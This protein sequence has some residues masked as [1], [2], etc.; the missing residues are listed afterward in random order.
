ML[1]HPWRSEIYVFGKKLINVFK[2][3]EMELNITKL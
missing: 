1:E 2:N 3:K